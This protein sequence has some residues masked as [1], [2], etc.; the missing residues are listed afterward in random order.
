MHDIAI[1]YKIAFRG[2][3][4]LI[5]KKECRRHRQNPNIKKKDWSQWNSQPIWLTELVAVK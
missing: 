2:A 1:N 4:P 3:L 5:T